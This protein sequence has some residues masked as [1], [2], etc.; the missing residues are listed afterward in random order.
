MKKGRALADITLKF[1]T[2]L[3]T[4]IYFKS[5]P[6]TNSTHNSWNLGIRWYTDIVNTTTLLSTVLTSI[7]LFDRATFFVW[8]NMRYSASSVV[9][10]T[11]SVTSI[12]W[13]VK[14]ASANMTTKHLSMSI[15]FINFFERNSDNSVSFSLHLRKAGPSFGR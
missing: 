12:S 11:K 5:F 10:G 9:H 1:D 7:L 2:I 8:R 3:W 6:F 13:F 14:A 15:S 4:G